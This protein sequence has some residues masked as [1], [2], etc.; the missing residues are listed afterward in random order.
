[1]PVSL[2]GSTS[3]SVTLTAPAVAGTTTLTFPAT[4]GTINASGTVNEVPAGSAAAPSIYS[5]G[6]TNTGIFFPAADTIAFTEGGAEAMRIDSSGQVGIGTSSPAGQLDVSQ[7]TAGVAR[8]Y[9]RNTSSSVSAYTI[10]DLVNNTGSNIGEFFCTSSTNTSAFGTNATVLQA[11]T[12]NPLIFGTNG[13]ER[14]R[15][16]SSGIVTGTA[17]NLMLIS[18]TSVASTSGTAITFTGIPS[19]VKRITVMLSGVSTNGTSAVQIQLGDAG[20]FEITGYSGSATGG[21]SGVSSTAMSAGFLIESAASLLAANTRSGNIV[22]TQ[23]SANLYSA[24]GA[25]AYGS[26]AISMMC[27]GSKTLSDTLTQVRIT[28]VN[29]TDTFD[30]GTINIMY[31]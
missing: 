14:M 24:S 30:A 22:I 29:G 27:G 13:T 6:D 4:T 3:G 17:G 28:T 25:T 11:A 19:Y 12:S 8:H 31:E 7:S 1:M 26:S 15:I 16:D 10:L 18:G 20:G 5:T 23:I 2:N 9:L 21:G